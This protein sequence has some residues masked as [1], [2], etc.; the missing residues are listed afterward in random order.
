MFIAVLFTIAK[1]WKQSRCLTTDKWF[2]K[3]WYFYTIE[4]YS[5]MKRNEILLF[6]CKW[7]ELDNVILSKISQA[8]KIKNRMLSLICGLYVKGK[9][10]NVIG[11][12]LHKASAHKGGIRI[13]KKPKKHDS[14]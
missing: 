7:M 9:Y 8:K 2:K 6:S 1:L 5:A 3:M 12:W 4:F 14:I 11:F 13:G 10:S